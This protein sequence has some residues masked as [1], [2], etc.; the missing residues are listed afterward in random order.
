MQYAGEK[1]RLFRLAVVQGYAKNFDWATETGAPISLVQRWIREFYA[2]VGPMELP[3]CPRLVNRYMIGADPEFAFMDEG[4]YIHAEKIGMN[5]LLPFGCDMAGRQAE[6]RAEPSRWAVEVLASMTDALRWIPT[7]HPQANTLKWC[8]MPVIGLDG[9]G[10]HW[11]IGRKRPNRDLEVKVLDSVTF[12]LSQ[13]GVYNREKMHERQRVTKFGR[14]GDVRLQTHG[15]EY[16][17]A[18]TWL[19]S[20]LGA[21]IACVA[22]K[23]AVLFET[24]L[25]YGKDIESA[26][27]RILNLFRYYRGLDDDAKLALRAIEVHGFPVAHE[28]DFKDNWGILRNGKPKKISKHFLPISLQPELTTV[29]EL[30]NHFN[31]GTKIPA[32][33]PKVTH[34]PFELKNLY[35]VEV[36]AHHFDVPNLA[37]GLL[38]R[39]C[40]VVVATGHE[41]LIMTGLHLPKSN[42]IKKKL[43]E[44]DKGFRLLHSKHAGTQI[45]ITVDRN[46]T[47]KREKLN[48]LR[49]FVSNPNFFPICKGKDALNVDWI[50]WDKVIENVAKPIPD[51]PLQGL[52]LLN[53]QGT[54]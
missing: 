28:D 23:L 36:V 52:L 27:L 15:Y 6:L 1:D 43:K 7:F 44:I 24:P 16:R 5:T 35:P 37:Q 12:T 46:T 25:H 17:T 2:P 19:Y 45:C 9:C 22:N 10:G 51:A 42:E 40:Q 53:V 18:P 41:N 33:D 13:T 38:S 14:P 50:E 48:E 47:Q 8:A 20:P 4:V 26:K 11:H 3:S 49:A 34:T 54:R 31:D 30:F 32:R 21:Y 39:V 29:I